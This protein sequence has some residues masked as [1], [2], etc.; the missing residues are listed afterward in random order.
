MKPVYCG[1]RDNCSRIVHFN[2]YVSRSHFQI[3]KN[4]IKDKNYF[5]GYF[6]FVYILRTHRDD[7]LY[8][9]K[10]LKIAF[11]DF[12]VMNVIL[13]AGIL[14]IFI[15]SIIFLPTC[16]YYLAIPNYQYD[17][18]QLSIVQKHLKV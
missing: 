2:Q 11:N 4:P 18:T 5:E 16:N 13:E 8:S 1:L 17:P 14:R 7:S 9:T 12:F 6:D 10:R 3:S 15:R